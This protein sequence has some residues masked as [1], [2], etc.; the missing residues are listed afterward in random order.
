ML[1]APDAIWVLLGALV[2]D[3]VI[4]DPDAIWR[5]LPHPVAWLGRLVAWGDARLNREASGPA[6]RRVAGTAWLAALLTLAIGGGWLVEHLL[7]ALPWGPA[8]VALA[9]S[10]LIAQRSLY[11]HVARVRDALGEGL[12][13]ARRAVSMIVGRDTAALDEA[14]I[15]RAAIESTAE[16][17]SDGVVAPAFWLAVGGLPGLLAYK[18]VNTADSMIGHLSERHRDFGWAAARLDDAL[19]L[20]PARASALLIALAAPSAGGSIGRA[21]ATTWRDA[22]THRSPNAGWPEASM[23]GALGVAL[24]GPRLYAAGP[25]E[26][27]FLF[28]EGRRDAGRRDIGRSL[29]VMTGAALLHAAMW[30]ALALAL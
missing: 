18:A 12:P 22:Q 15:A 14:G 6:A 2:L 9:A 26:A 11:E 1:L 20:V 17:F 8:W 7:R 3:A 10:V 28:A 13:A 4:G 30:G 24:G 23:A 29:R 19:N 5:R 27:P 16:N 21:L 25:V